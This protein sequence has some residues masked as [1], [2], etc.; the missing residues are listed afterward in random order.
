MTRRQPLSLFHSQ[1]Q[2]L[3]LALS[4]GKMG[5]LIYFFEREPS[6]SK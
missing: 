1:Q 3:L 6:V 5:Q 4:D 2:Q